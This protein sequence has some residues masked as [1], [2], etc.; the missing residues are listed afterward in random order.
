MNAR[1]TTDYFVNGTIY[2]PKARLQMTGSSDLTVT[3]KSGYVITKQFAYQ[4]D[5]AFTMDTFGGPVPS[6]PCRAA[7][8]HRAIVG[9]G[10][11]PAQRVG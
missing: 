7:N 10:S 2:L 1:G 3:A 5:S 6:A 8:C 11:I 9:R 4:G